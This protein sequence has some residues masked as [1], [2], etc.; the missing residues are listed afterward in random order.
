[1]LYSIWQYFNPDNHTL[2]FKQPSY[3]RCAL[4]IILETSMGFEMDIQNKRHTPYATAIANIVH[5]FQLRQFIPWY[6]NSNIYIANDRGFSFTHWNESLWFYVCN[7]R[8]MPDILFDWFSKYRNEHQDNLRVLHGFT[9]SVITSRRQQMLDD[10]DEL[11]TSAEGAKKRKLAF[12]DLLLKFQLSGGETSLTD[13]DIREEVESRILNQKSFNL[14]YI[15]DIE[16]HD[17][18]YAKFFLF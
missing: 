3:F 10:L 16:V 2:S 17:T 4:D 9:E 5:I 14:W 15:S 12:L 18:L 13:R 1:M 6:V 11:K 7:L 8:Y